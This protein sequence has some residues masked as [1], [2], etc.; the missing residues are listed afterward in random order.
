MT[1]SY[2][3]F[4]TS[5]VAAAGQLVVACAGPALAVSRILPFLTGVTARQTINLSDEQPA[6][7]SLLKSISNTFVVNMIEA[8]AEAMVLADKS[9]LGT[10]YMQDLAKVLWPGPSAFYA[11]RM[12]SGLYAD[13]Q[14]RSSMVF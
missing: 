11:E 5:N 1:N 4:G 7:A 13:G 6:K 2:S 9:G 8:T 3:V 10:K 12:G 14:V